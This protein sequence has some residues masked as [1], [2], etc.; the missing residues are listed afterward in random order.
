M[1]SRV[2]VLYAD[3]TPMD[4]VANP[5]PHQLYRNPRIVVERRELGELK[6]DEI[7]GE[8]LYAGLCGTDLHLVETNPRTGYILCSAPAS[9]GEQGRVIGHEAVARVLAVGSRVKHVKRGDIVTFESIITCQHC[10]V[11]RRGQFNQC[12]S[13]Q[14]LGLETD[15]LFGTV[16]DVPSMLAHDVTTLCKDE[17][18]LRAAACI[19]PAGVAYVAC[20]TTRIG[21]GDSV[22]IFGAGPIG[23]FVAQF[24]RLIF[25]ASQVFVIE[26]IEFRRSLVKKWGDQVYDVEEFY[27]EGP[28]RVD[29]IIEASGF[30]DNVRKTF[31]R[32][33]PNGRVALLGRSGTP[34][35]FDAVDHLITNAISVMGSRGHLCGAFSNILKLA[36][37]KRIDL[38]QI[39]TEV[40]QGPEGIREVLASPGRIAHNCKIL[41]KFD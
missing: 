32:L 22:A 10:E 30:V 15:G 40:V 38:D 39:V 7:R 31:R 14:L 16:V 6:A 17:R 24:S 23:A 29:V 11:C 34:L 13:A 26:P 9:I 41:A 27:E 37:R 33:N 12:L 25:G 28:R 20:E 19:E 3:K 18:G 36:L 2:V 4:G 5:G 21:P 35:T 1:D 8:I